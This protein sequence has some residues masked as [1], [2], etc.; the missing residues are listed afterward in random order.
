MF[1]NRNGARLFYV[2]QGSGS[3][4]L[5]FIHG[6]A[7]DHT[8]WDEHLAHFAPKHRVVAM[9][10]R[11][12][13]QSDGTDKFTP[14]MF[15][16]D[17]ATLIRELGLAPAVLVGASRGGGI[18]NRVAVDYPDLVKAVVMVDYGAASHRSEAAPWA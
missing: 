10:L 17:L 14:E 12:H 18:A 15:R 16:D 4:P 3:P 11:G 2:E 7:V 5:V 9:D 8:T 13:G 1:V 6:G